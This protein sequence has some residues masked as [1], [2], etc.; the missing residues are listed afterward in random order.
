MVVSPATSNRSLIEMGRPS[1]AE[2]V[3]P[4]ARSAS[5][6]RASARAC[7]AYTRVKTRAPSPAGSAARARAACVS[8][9]EVSRPSC[10]ARL[11]CFNVGSMGTIRVPRRG[12]W[13]LRKGPPAAQAISGNTSTS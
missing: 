7:S 5:A 6:A 3:T 12:G 8:P 9:L 2:R 1:M 4:A 10:K 11:C 13:G